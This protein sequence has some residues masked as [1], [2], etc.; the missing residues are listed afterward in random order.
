MKKKKHVLV[1][2]E[3]NKLSQKIKVIPTKGLTKDSIKKIQYSEC[4]FKYFALDILQ[5]YLVFVSAN[6]Y[7]EF[8]NT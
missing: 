6:K 1:Q 3:L 5:S 7:I 2:N 8:F 4:C